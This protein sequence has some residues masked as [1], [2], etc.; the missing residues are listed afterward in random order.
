[1]KNWTHKVVKKQ[2]GMQ[3]E[4]FA[5]PAA[6]TGTEAECRKYAEQFAASQRVAGVV[7]TKI[8]VESRK[9]FAGPY[10]PTNHVA[11]YRVD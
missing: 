6:M 1:M 8:V 4:W 7:G 11:T 2:R 9:R 10:G 5:Y 3:G